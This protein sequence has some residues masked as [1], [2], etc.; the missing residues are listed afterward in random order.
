MFSR[1]LCI[2]AAFERHEFDELGLAGRLAHF[3]E[4]NMRTAR[5]S[6]ARTHIGLMPAPA[7]PPLLWGEP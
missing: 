3:E 5:P 2:L 1:I 4:L 6:R 7:P